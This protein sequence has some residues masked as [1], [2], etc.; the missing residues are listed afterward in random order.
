MGG[1]SPRLGGCPR[2]RN[3]P[4]RRARDLR[5][6]APGLGLRSRQARVQALV[7]R[8]ALGPGERLARTHAGRPGDDRPALDP[9]A[10]APC[11]EDGEAA[12]ANFSAVAARALPR[13][14][15]ALEPLT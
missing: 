14:L 9:G 10:F 13:R 1:A 11:S 15:A 3:G 7:L 2:G 4:N 5:A 8:D 12:S 6:A